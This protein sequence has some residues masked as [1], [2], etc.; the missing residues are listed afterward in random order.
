MRCKECKGNEWEIVWASVLIEEAH[1][2]DLVQC[3]GCKR[4]VMVT[5]DYLEDETVEA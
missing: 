1:R 2:V 5:Q 3:K 4:V